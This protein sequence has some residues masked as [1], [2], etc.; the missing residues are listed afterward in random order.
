[1]AAL[2]PARPA[3]S[4]ARFEGLEPED[5]IRAF[6]VMHTS[7]RLDD[8]EIPLKRQNRIFFQISGAG[9]EAVLAAAGMA[10]RPRP[11]LVLPLLPRPRAVPGAR[12]DARR[13]AA[14]GGGRG[15]GPASGGRQMPS[16]WGH[17]ELNIVSQILAHRHA[18]PAG[19]GMRR[20]VAATCDPRERRGDPGHLRRGRHQRGR[21]LGGAEHR[22][23]RT[24]CRCC[25]WS[26]TTATP[27]PCPSRS[28]P[29][30]ATSR[31]WSRLSRTCSGQEVDG[32]RL[33]RLL[34]R[35]A[36]G[37]RVL[38]RAPGAGAGA[39]P[40]D[41]ALL[42]LALRRRAAVQDRRPSARPRPRAI[43][44]SRFPQW[45]VDGGHARP[46][47]RC[48]DRSRGRPG[49]PRGHRRGPARDAARAARPALLHLY[50]ETVDPASDAFA[51]R[52]ASSTA[53]RR[54]MVDRST[55]RCATRCGAT[56]HRGLRR[57]R[58]RCSREE[59]LARGEGQG[60]RLQGDRR[61]ADANSAPARAST[62][63]W[64]R[65]TSWAAPSAW[66]RAG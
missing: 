28:R 60:R 41:P 6:R 40:R 55:S 24:A 58:G 18:V 7:R 64:P 12:R 36:A 54:T 39:R 42:A 16:H 61:A 44:S 5:L 34:P 27:S 26:R 65:P 21:V 9:H 47:R 32:M 14:R 57:G 20:G 56:P 11:R 63:R 37:R 48:S 43:P 38:P 35:H 13:D 8:R 3:V 15:G 45:L 46:P 66:P 10:L 19:G 17:R 33:R 30:A 52:A 1:M 4:A 50:S 53:S 23:P 62:R 31:G 49:D 2:I 51:S 59:H 25:S 29:P 22:L